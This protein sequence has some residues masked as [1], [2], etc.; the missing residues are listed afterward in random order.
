MFFSVTLILIS[1]L[2][3]IEFAGLPLLVV[4]NEPEPLILPLLSHELIELLDLVLPVFEFIL[5]FGKVFLEGGAQI[6]LHPMH[7]VHFRRFSLELAANHHVSVHA[8]VIYRW[9]ER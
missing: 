4:L 3:E 7:S 8:C 5:K 6:L 9:K 1:L 2:S